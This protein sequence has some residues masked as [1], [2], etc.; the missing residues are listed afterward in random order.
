MQPACCLDHSTVLPCTNCTALPCAV[1]Q[2]MWS[3][4]TPELYALFWTLSIHDIYVP[5][6]AYESE[7]DKVRVQP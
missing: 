2:T 4:F 6:K 5:T 1:L 7:M 3:G